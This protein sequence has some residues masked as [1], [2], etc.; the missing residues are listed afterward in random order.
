MSAFTLSPPK[1]GQTAS[2]QLLPCG[3]ERRG[4]ACGRDARDG[5]VHGGRRAA[6][7]TPWFN[8]TD[9]WQPR[10]ELNH[11]KHRRHLSSMDDEGLVF[12][13]RLLASALISSDWTKDTV[14]GADHQL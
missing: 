12:C 11:R 13:S 10:R 3:R 14:P 1:S 8:D 4:Q 7:A 5:P 2:G 6:E 9:A